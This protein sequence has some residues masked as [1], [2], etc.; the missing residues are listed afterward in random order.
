MQDGMNQ[1]DGLA[2]ALGCG[3][4][5]TRKTAENHLVCANE[6]CGQDLGP[7]FEISARNLEQDDQS[8][9]ENSGDKSN[10]QV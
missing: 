2:I 6:A 4:V 3:H 8:G 5:I 9:A 1:G 10:G 7:I